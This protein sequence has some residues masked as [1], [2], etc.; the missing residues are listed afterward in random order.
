MRFGCCTGSENYEVLAS[1]GYDFI[2]LS[3]YE[4]FSM[5]SQQWRNLKKKI[6][7]VGVP[8]I[9]FNDYC[10]HQPAIVGESF[11]PTAIRDYARR[12]LDRGAQIQIQN[13]GI[14]APTA[15]KL[16]PDY[17]RKKAEEQCC[18]F[19]EI[20]AKEAANLGIRVLFE[21]VHS[22]M[23]D[24]ANH[25]EDALRLIEE[26]DAPNLFMVLDFY[27]MEVMNEDQLA[28][29]P[30]V[31]YVRH[32][33]FSHCAAGYAREYPGPADQEQITKIITTLHSL[34]YDDS[35][36]VEAETRNFPVDAAQ[37]LAVF[38]RANGQ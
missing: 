38:R 30:Y 19:L 6:R 17:S 2:E 27:H 36:S 28:I 18:R 26:V 21:A 37:T 16:P 33:H 1:C 13:V 4:V 11:D 34:G 9:G 20:T 32:A 7:D 22:H 3:G 15:R 24:F 10:H 25:T 23:C 29:A 12:L 35:A 31:P 8:C 14:G 5:E